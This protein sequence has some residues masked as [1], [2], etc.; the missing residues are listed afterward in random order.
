MIST[1]TKTEQRGCA[2]ESL[3][4]YTEVNSSKTIGFEV[5]LQ[6]I[7]VN[8]SNTTIYYSITIVLL[9]TIKLLPYT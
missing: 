3:A 8:Y 9:G 1:A 5:I 6:F 7:I 4:K 2:G